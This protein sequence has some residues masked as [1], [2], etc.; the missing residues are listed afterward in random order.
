MNFA[1][2]VAGIA[3]ILITLV[4]IGSFAYHIYQFI[5]N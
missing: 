2:I 4:I 1:K 5:N 3:T